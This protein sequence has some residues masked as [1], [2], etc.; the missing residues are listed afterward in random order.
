MRHRDEGLSLAGKVAYFVHLHLNTVKEIGPSPE[1]SDERVYSV[2]GKARPMVVMCRERKLERDKN[3]YLVLP[4]FSNGLDAG[5]KLKQYFEPIGDCLET[6]HESFVH[7]VPLRLPENMLSTRD[8][9]SALLKPIDPLAFAHALKS[10]TRKCL[11]FPN[12]DADI[13]GINQGDRS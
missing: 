6:S 9:R 13:R 5:G 8:G 12:V 4:V 2:I 3:W 1:I 11:R 7:L 10:L